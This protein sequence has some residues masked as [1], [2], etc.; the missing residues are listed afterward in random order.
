[1]RILESP[2]GYWC[3]RTIVGRTVSDADGRMPLDTIPLPDSPEVLRAPVLDLLQ[4]QEASEAEGARRAHHITWQEASSPRK[5]SISRWAAKPRP[6][7]ESTSPNCSAGDL[8]AVR[9]N[10]P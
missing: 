4:K 5:T 6:R 9:K 7:L 3:L 2:Y 10:S 1:M 8:G